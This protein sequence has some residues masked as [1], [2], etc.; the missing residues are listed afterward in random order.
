MAE[1]KLSVSKVKEDIRTGKI[2]G[3]VTVR[4]GSESSAM[5]EIKT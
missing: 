1:K 2:T 4:G 3:F 5:R